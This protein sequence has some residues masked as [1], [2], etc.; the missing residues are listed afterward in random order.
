[1]GLILHDQIAHLHTQF[2]RGAKVSFEHL[3]FPDLRNSLRL[4]FFFQFLSKYRFCSAHSIAP[5]EH[6]SDGGSTEDICTPTL[7]KRLFLKG[8][9]LRK[10]PGAGR[11]ENSSLQLTAFKELGVSEL[12]VVSDPSMLSRVS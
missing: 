9:A 10:Q 7:R 1:M 8:K 6:S 5:C 3:R 11:K 2:S 4:F 12:W